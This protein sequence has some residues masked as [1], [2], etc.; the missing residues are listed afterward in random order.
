MICIEMGERWNYEA[1]E[2]TRSQGK[3]NSKIGN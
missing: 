2:E 3:R 1:H